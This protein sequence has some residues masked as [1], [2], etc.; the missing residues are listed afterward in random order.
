MNTNTIL[1]IDSLLDDTLDHVEDVPDFVT[2]PEGDYLLSIPSAE[3]KKSDDQKKAARI[4]LTYSVDSL[5]QISN[6]KDIPVA[7]GAMFTESFQATE[8][9]LKYFKKQAK[10]LLNVE[11]ITGVSMREILSSLA[12]VKQMP[13]RIKIN[14]T[15]KKDESGTVVGSYE[16]VRITPTY[17]GQTQEQEAA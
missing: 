2:P 9:G 7:E 1:D 8:E 6:A 11:D 10:K 15:P 3:I 14:R 5:V 16:N 13:A 4:V 17:P 12:E